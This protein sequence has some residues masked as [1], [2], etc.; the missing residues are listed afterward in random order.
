[1]AD[2]EDHLA[3]ARRAAA[4]AEGRE[5]AEGKALRA[6][7]LDRE[8]RISAWARCAESIL[9][10][11]AAKRVKGRKKLTQEVIAKSLGWDRSKVSRL[12]SW[13]G[14]ADSP[15]PDTLPFG[16]TDAMTRLVDAH[17]R[18]T[19]RE[20]PEVVLEEV[21]LDPA[22]ARRFVDDL[23]PHAAP[24]PKYEYAAPPPPLWEDG[25]VHTAHFPDPPERKP[26]WLYREVL[27]HASLLTTWLDDLK[28]SALKPNERAEI[29]A[30]LRETHEA[31][32]RTLARLVEV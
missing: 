20:R 21:K 25:F 27:E 32:A 2:V 7:E 12:L 3:E 18:R 19:I 14:P 17:A 30:Q 29:V 15:V 23:L 13:R 4:E 24:P 1:M 22:L 9:A 5:L 16:G 28:P 6:A 26:D 11:I 31:V 10:A 8:M